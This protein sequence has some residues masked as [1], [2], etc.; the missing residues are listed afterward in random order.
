MTTKRIAVVCAL[1]GSPNTGMFTVDHAAFAFFRTHFPEC[2]TSFYALGDVARH[3]F[4]GI[5]PFALQ[6]LPQCFPAMLAADAIV[7]WGDFLH[8]RNYWPAVMRRLVDAGL[9]P[10][11]Q[12]A[13]DLVYRTFMLEGAPPATRAKAILFGST[14]IT[15]TSEDLADARYAAALAT[16]CAGAR[17]VL[18]RDPVSTAQVSGPGVAQGCDAALLPLMKARGKADG[19]IGVFFGRGRLRDTFQYHR[20]ARQTARRM[21]A[22]ARWVSWLRIAPRAQRLAWLFGHRR[23]AL[24]PSP[25]DALAQLESV[26]FVVTD[27][28]HITL[29]AW[30]RGIPAICIGRRD[31]PSRDA[32]TDRKKEVVYRMLGAENFY[33]FADQIASRAGLARES[34]RAAAMLHDRPAIAAVT[35]AVTQLGDAVQAKL[36][37]ALNAL[38]R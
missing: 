1:P 20:L 8:A 32:L 21:N 24:A 10:D 33:V 36:L 4:G 37:A 15:N 13:T 38:L 31:D 16:L 3:P 23:T 27:T 2:E 6:P 26:S 18:L 14:L 11:S 35:H 28:Y 22:K 7:Y 9:S 17:A 12:S 34:A 29:N 25:Q 19:T 30:R 5:L